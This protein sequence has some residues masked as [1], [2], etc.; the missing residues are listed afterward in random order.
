MPKALKRNIVSLFISILHWN[1]HKNAKKLGTKLPASDITTKYVTSIN[2]VLAS[3]VFLRN[4]YYFQR[5]LDTT[6]VPEYVA[7]FR[8]YL[9]TILKTLFVAL[10]LMFTIYQRFRGIVYNMKFI[11]KVS[12]RCRNF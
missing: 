8:A 10:I 12:G 9:V 11:V 1:I 7:F 3:A 2:A 5:F 4:A 6:T